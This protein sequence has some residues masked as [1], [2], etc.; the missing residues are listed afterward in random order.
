MTDQLPPNPAD[1]SSNP[2]PLTNPPPDEGP[3]SLAGQFGRTRDS[4]RGL[5]TAH[6]DLFKAEMGEILDLVKVLGTLAGLMLAMALLV[7]VMLYVG[8]F[9]FLGEWLFG[10][11]GWGFGQGLVFGIAL[12]VN[13]ALA[14]VGASAG[15]LAAAFLLAFFI[16]VGIAL[17]CGSNIV[18]TAT[19]GVSGSLAPPLGTP[20]V[21]A[22]LAGII[23][24]AILFTLLFSIMA[25]RK[26]AIGGFFLGAFLGAFVGWLIGGAPWTWQP[27]VGFAILIALIAWPILAAVLVIPTLDMEARFGRLKPQ[28]SIDAANET[29]EWLEEQW[30][31]RQPKLGNR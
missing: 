11:I 12:I 14:F 30:R 19:S 22:L 13:L 9:L 5:V 17:L 10:S 1:S 4:F 24:G 31:K 20:G 21:V 15:R 7:M 2:A 27:A 28:Q 8:G 18:Y 26:G 3:T 23:V 29:R 6:I 25:G 16:A